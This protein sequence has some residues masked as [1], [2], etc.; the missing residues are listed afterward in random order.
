ME[1]KFNM[2]K[3]GFSLFPAFFRAYPMPSHDVG[4][5]WR[6]AMPPRFQVTLSPKTGHNPFIGAA[7]I[8]EIRIHPRRMTVPGEH[9]GNDYQGLARRIRE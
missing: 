9:H 7:R 5:T 4:L 1:T 8:L 3:S 2:C 6:L